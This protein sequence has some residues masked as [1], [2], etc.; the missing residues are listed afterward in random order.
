MHPWLVFGVMEPVRGEASALKLVHYLSLFVFEAMG[1]VMAEPGAL[2]R[3]LCL[4]MVPYVAIKLGVVEASA[5]TLGLQLQMVALLWTSY[6]MHYCSFGDYVQTE[7]VSKEQFPDFQLGNVY[8]EYCY[9][10]EV[11]RVLGE[12]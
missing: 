10:P 4:W 12:L 11:R 2:A 1:L 8:T 7:A 3:G 6:S 9:L 5:W